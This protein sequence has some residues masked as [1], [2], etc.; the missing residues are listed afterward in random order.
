MP[1]RSVCRVENSPGLLQAQSAGVTRQFEV[2]KLDEA[3]EGALIQV[4]D[5]ALTP[6]W[7]SSPKR[8]LITIAA[9]FAGFILGLF[10]AL[11]KVGL[12]RMREDPEIDTKLSSFRQAISLKR[13]HAL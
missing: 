6:D 4:V 3:K 12:E 5:P 7:K 10:W 8:A 11:A 9:T 2:A 13:T 1:R